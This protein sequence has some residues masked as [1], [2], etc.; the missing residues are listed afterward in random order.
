MA[1]FL[2]LRFAESPTEPVEWVVV[3]Q[4]GAQQGSDRT[5]RSAGPWPKR[6][7]DK[8]V[9]A[10][11]PGTNVLR[12]F[13]DIPVRNQAKLLQA[14]PFAMEDQLAGNIEELHFA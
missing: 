6:P 13:V 1:D 3:D 10:L 5:R 12:T 2:V 7:T 14:I 8:R 4:S 9:I 11:V